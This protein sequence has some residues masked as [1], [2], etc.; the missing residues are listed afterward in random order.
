MLYPCHPALPKA[1]QEKFL[2]QRSP[3]VRVLACNAAPLNAVGVTNPDTAPRSVTSKKANTFI[4]PKMCTCALCCQRW[5][6]SVQ[7]VALIVPFESMC[8]VPLQNLDGQRKLELTTRICPTHEIQNASTH[9][10]S[11]NWITTLVP[12]YRLREVLQT[13][14]SQINATRRDAIPS[15]VCPTGSRWLIVR[16][17]PPRT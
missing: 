1:G 16:R 7:G 13:S 6:S 10:F 4:F 15:G 8:C 3:R 17:N 9:A 12:K 5:A 11:T 14:L 2:G